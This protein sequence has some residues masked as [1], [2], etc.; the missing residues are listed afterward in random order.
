MSETKL[1]EKQKL[2]DW[3]RNVPESDIRRLLKYRVKYYFAGGLPGNQPLS[4]MKTIISQIVD[5]IDIT[6][7]KSN[8]FNYGPTAGLEHFRQ[9]LADRLVSKEKLTLPNQYEDV[10]ISTGSQQKLY[11]LLKVMINPKD[12][13]L[14]TRPTY[15]GFLG[16]AATLDAQIITI[17][18]DQDGIIPEGIHS[19]CKLS[20]KIFARIPKIL[21]VQSY[22]ENPTGITIS[23]SRR[24]LI[25]DI[26][27][28]YG[29]FIIEDA[30]YKEIQFGRSQILPLKVFD[31][32][33]ENVAYLSTSSK[34]AVVFRIGYSV[35]PNR[36]KTEFVK[37]KGYLDLCTPNFTQ[38]IASR[39]YENH[40]DDSLKIINEAYSKQCSAMKDAIDDHLPG[41]RTNPEGG[42]FVWH[43]LP[44]VNTFKLLSKAIENEVLFVPG[45]AFYPLSGYHLDES[46]SN[47]EII[48]VPDDELRFSYSDLN[49]NDIY[50]GIIKLSKL[51]S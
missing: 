10:V 20:L 16:T 28:E 3:T 12:V 8:L 5:E 44:K 25:Y 45:K 27:Q 37:L 46:L 41:V 32:E 24:K 50:D 14:T 35:L 49:P 26:A 42:F 21:Y 19:A 6:Q 29:I 13:I 7:S 40:I 51:V 34:E 36:I 30:A 48:D 47:L 39:Y 33:N 22:S 31:K 9:I 18:S 23:P 43:K 4:T 38:E 15:L 1:I 11:G 17:P 2:A